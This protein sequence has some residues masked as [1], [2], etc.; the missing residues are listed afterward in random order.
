MYTWLIDWLIKQQPE[1]SLWQCLQGTVWSSCSNSS[2]VFLGQGVFEIP[3]EATVRIEA[4]TRSVESIES[5]KQPVELQGASEWTHWARIVQKKCYWVKTE[6]SSDEED[7][8][9]TTEQ[10]KMIVIN[11]CNGN[12]VAV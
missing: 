1:R 2:H 10:L 11:V 9:I 8:N 4:C 7:Q 6:S 12:T 3:V 5:F